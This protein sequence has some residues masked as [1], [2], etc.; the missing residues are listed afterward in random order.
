MRKASCDPEVLGTVADARRAR[1]KL[2][3]HTAHLVLA[4][5]RGHGRCA[6]GHASNL[7]R[8]VLAH[9]GV[10]DLAATALEEH[11][12]LPRDLLTDVWNGRLR[13]PRLARRIPRQNAC[14]HGIRLLG[15]LVWHSTHMIQQKNMGLII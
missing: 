12:I 4:A 14:L 13:C 7:R 11:L 5:T 3:C 10:D 8:A 2:R 9:I 1:G 15:L 6:R